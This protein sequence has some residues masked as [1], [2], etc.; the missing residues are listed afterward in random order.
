MNEK[1]KVAVLFGGRSPEHDISIVTG[2]QTLQAIDTSKY[3]PFPVYLDTDGVWWTGDV[4]RERSNYLLTETMKNKLTAVRLDLAH[5][6]KGILYP[7]RSS[8]FKIRQPIVFDIALP[9]FHGLIGEDGGIQGVFETAGIPYT[10][11]RLLSSS[12][13]MDKVITKNVLRQ[14][15][16]PV[17]PC[18]VIAKPDQGLLLEPTQLDRVC[19][20][21][22]FPACIKPRFLGSSLGVA[23][24]NSAGEL[25]AV[26]PRIFKYDSHAVLEPFVDNLVEY[27]IA[28]RRSGADIV[29]SAIEMPKRS[30]ELLD[31]KQKYCSGGTEN[32]GSK[33]KAG[34]KTTML[35]EGMLSL[36]REIDPKLNQQDIQ[37]IQRWAKTAFQAVD[38]T[39]APRMDFL[40]NQ[41]TGEIWLNEVNPIPGSFGFF[42]WEAAEKSLLFTELLN[43]LLEEAV[44]QAKLRKLPHDP[45]P[46]EGRLFVRR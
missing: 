14:V 31:F 43:C 15:N 8:F 41:K 6:R 35:S 33:G 17:L 22:T 27:N 37:N 45:V 23:K 30:D 9:A 46:E 16:I 40:S 36:T 25:N 29:C 7:L 39:G 21:I 24:V 28:V 26:L 10:G 19:S 11:M 5:H 44:G 38:G 18:T 20:D 34:S 13:L 1:Q 2:L 32:W 3:D 4:L 12:L 42:L